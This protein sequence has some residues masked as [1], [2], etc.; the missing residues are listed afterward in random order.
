[1]TPADAFQRIRDEG[2][3]S[4]R[5][6]LVFQAIFTA[7]SATGKQLRASLSYASAHKRLSE[8]RALGVVEASSGSSAAEWRVTGRLP[9]GRVPKKRRARG[10]RPSQADLYRAV[11]ALRQLWR[12]GVAVGLDS[13]APLARVGAWLAQGAP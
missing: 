9:S 4:E 12:V 6:F 13:S 8:L 7:G 5:Q 10:E 2:L 11:D 1:M 3:L